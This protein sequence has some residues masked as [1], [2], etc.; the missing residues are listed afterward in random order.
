FGDYRRNPPRFFSLYRDFLAAG[1]FHGVHSHLNH[2]SGLFLY[3]PNKLG[4]PLRIVHY[5]S[6]FKYHNHYTPKYA[7][8]KLFGFFSEKYSNKVLG[9]SDACLDSVYGSS[10]KGNH[11][12]ERIY[13]GIDLA[14][15]S[16]TRS[17]LLKPQDFGIKDN[18]LVIGHVGQFR[19]EKNHQFLLEFAE[20]IC[21]LNRHVVF[22]FVGDGPLLEHTRNEAAARG[23]DG[24]I[25]FT[26]TRPDV[27]NLLGI[28]DLFVFPSLWEGF[29][30]AVVEAEAAGLPVIMS[31]N[32]PDEIPLI[33]PSVKLPLDNMTIWVDA[34]RNLIE[35]VK[36]NNRRKKSIPS[37]LKEFSLD[38]WVRNIERVYSEVRP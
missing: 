20:K 30:M 15:L 12:I 3:A 4:M 35:Y 14:G 5:H 32:I 36:K 25:I 18:S 16:S 34:C 19:K 8:R 6:D 21:A 24:R 23:L 11:K 31:T 29:G 10:W 37:E 26:G 38:T 33:E 1:N 7:L 9:I 13:N 2:L 27:P 22:L 17:F 28:M